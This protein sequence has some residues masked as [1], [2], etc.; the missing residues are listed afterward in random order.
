MPPACNAAIAAAATSTHRPS[1]PE[2]AQLHSEY[3]ATDAHTVG[4]KKRRAAPPLVRAKYR[5]SHSATIGATNV[6]AV[7]SQAFRSAPPSAAI[8]GVRAN[9]AIHTAA[10][11]FCL[12]GI[13]G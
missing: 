11:R 4:Q 9:D 3:A 1:Q 6:Q 2:R 5:H 13:A 10:M 8:I 7:R 12:F